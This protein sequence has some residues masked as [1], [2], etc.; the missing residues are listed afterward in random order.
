M[1]VMP[2]LRRKLADDVAGKDVLSFEDVQAGTDYEYSVTGNG[3]KENIVVKEKADRYRY[4]FILHQENVTAEFDETK[5]RVAF[6]SNE[7]GEE[8]F[9]IPAPFMTDA[10]GIISTAVDFEVKTKD[11]GFR[12]CLSSS[13]LC[14]TSPAASW[15]ADGR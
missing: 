15:R 2:K 10:N 1:G 3:V 7:T 14:P 5:N 4:A 6:L 13:V 8:V 11:S 12:L 9:F